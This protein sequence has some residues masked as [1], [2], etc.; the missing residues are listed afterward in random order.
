MIEATSDY[1]ANVKAQL[2]TVLED[3]YHVLNWTNSQWRT[4]WMLDSSPLAIKHSRKIDERTRNM[5]RQKKRGDEK[6]AEICPRQWEIV[7]RELLF[8]WLI[9][10]ERRKVIF[11]STCFFADIL[12]G[13]SARELIERETSRK[14]NENWKQTALKVIIEM[15]NENENTL[16]RALL[17]T[18]AIITFFGK[19][20]S[21]YFQFSC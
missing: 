17:S 9:A 4:K 18:L 7:L 14:K 10:D 1:Q 20:Y 11:S 3:H 16:S 8:R 12:D 13:S 15:E 2:M 5:I 21:N 19:F 6:I